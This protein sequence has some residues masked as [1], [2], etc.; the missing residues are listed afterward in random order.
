M[1]DMNMPAGTI[2]AP[3]SRAFVQCRQFLLKC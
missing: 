3:L 1:Q 2:A